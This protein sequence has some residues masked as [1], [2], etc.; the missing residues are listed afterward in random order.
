MNIRFLI[1]AAVAAI[2]I[3]V[4]AQG[5][6]PTGTQG[7]TGGMRFGAPGQGGGMRRGMPEELKKALALTPAQEKKMQAINDKY[8]AKFPKF[9]PGQRPSEAE[10]AKLKPIMDA[11]RKEREAVYT[12]K[13][14]AILEKWRKDHPRGMGGPG[15]S[16]RVQGGKP[17]TAKG[18][19]SKGGG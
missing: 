17:P 10:I 16:A 5:K 2:S 6:P 12:P 8:R 3:S 14:K 19:G 9:T 7:K 15:G 11:M 13:Q 18:G 4:F 1:T